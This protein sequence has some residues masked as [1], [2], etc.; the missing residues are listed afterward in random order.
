ML[1]SKKFSNISKL[2]GNF[3]AIFAAISGFSYVIGLLIIRTYLSS[4]GIFEFSSL[5]VRYITIGVIFSIFVVAPAILIF[6]PIITYQKIRSKVHRLSAVLSAVLLSLVLYCLISFFL[7]FIFDVPC[8]GSLEFIWK[9]WKYYS[10]EPWFFS[11]YCIVFGLMTVCNYCIFSEKMR[12]GVY[13]FIFVLVAIFGIFLCFW[14]Y[15]GHV[16]KHVNPIFGGGRIQQVDIVLSK[17]GLE[18]AKKFHFLKSKSDVIRAYVVYEDDKNYFLTK[19][20][21]ENHK[22]VECFRIPKSLV[23]SIRHPIINKGRMIH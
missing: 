20:Y 11:V 13:A 22:Y 16:H 1:M 7:G 4:F 8:F 21:D 18:A 15:M 3:S 10:V 6:V 14:Y 2:L 12:D 23:S 19:R 5:S 17:D 9:A